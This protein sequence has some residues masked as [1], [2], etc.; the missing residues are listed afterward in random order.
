MNRLWKFIAVLC[1][2][3]AFGFGAG[4]QTNALVWHKDNGTVDA[5]MRHEPLIPL[6]KSI[7]KQSG[8]HVYVEAGSTVDASTKFKNLPVGD[9]LKMML[10]DLNFALVPKTNTAWQ[11][12]VFRTTMKNATQLVSARTPKHVPNELIVKVKPGTDINALAKM[13]GAKVIGKM[14]KYG[15]YL[16]QFA[17][18]DSTDDALSKL[19]MDS[20]VESVGYNNY[21]DP[22]PTPQALSSATAPSTV[23]LTLNPPP[24][25]GKVVVG[26]IDTGVQSLGPNMDQ[27]V[28]PEI[29]E[30]DGTSSDSGLTHGTAML[31]TILS[32]MGSVTGGNISAQVQPYDVYGSSSTANTWA[33]AQALAQAVN[34]G[35]NPIN[36]S[37]G[38]PDNDPTL[39][40]LIGQAAN[41]GYVIFAA[42]G[43][44]PTGDP[45][46]PAGDSGAY[47]VTALSQWGQ[48]APYANVWYDPT[49]LA[50][51]GTGLVNFDGQTWEVTGTSYSTAVASGGTVGNSQKNMWT[52][53]QTAPAMVNHFTVPK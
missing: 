28:L 27:F 16:L 32:T 35:N 42:S 4:A 47:A 45:Y 30:A 9:A 37:L 44:N 25:S 39:A 41:D 15:V 11:L 24:A 19:Q 52:I 31:Y 12:Y 43:N 49:M 33:V 53:Q 3:V 5:N 18:A 48:L 8:W 46:Y 20:D 10:G 7:A 14:D 51:P 38:S 40:S 34:N 23:A 6:L 13:L 2:L 22:P 21:Y 36:M 29:S 26:L 1:L 50:L 17:D